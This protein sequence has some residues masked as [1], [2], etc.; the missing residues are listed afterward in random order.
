MLAPVQWRRIA[1]WVC[2]WMYLVGN[3]TITLAVTFG[4]TQ[5]I[6]SCVNVFETANG[7][8]VLPGENYQ[9]FL[10]FLGMTFLCNAIS[11]LGNRWLPILD[12]RIVH[13]SNCSTL[14]FI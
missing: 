4:T 10:I 9:V 7:E 11:A 3:I 6:V 12:V 2:G 13:L 1:G 14:T 5:F 8:G